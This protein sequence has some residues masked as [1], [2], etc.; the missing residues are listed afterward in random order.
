[1]ADKQVAFVTIG[2][3][4]RT[5]MMPEMLDEIGPGIA[6]HEFGILDGLSADEVARLRPRGAGYRL[7]S[8]MA[9]GSEVEI[10]K[11]WAIEA[12]QRKLDAVDR[13]GFDLVVLLCTGSFPN[14][15]TRT[16]MVE[17]GRVIDNMVDAIGEEH[18]TV[19]VL[20]PNESQVASWQRSE[21]GKARAVAAHASPYTDRR[22]AAAV[23]ELDEA[24]FIVMHCMGYDRAMRDE[25]AALSGKPVLL[26][27]AMVA[28]AVT[29]LI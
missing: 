3:A 9:D 17:A 27:R 6:G 13:E 22:F 11:P 8:R 4:P 2:Q 21:P 28:S 18:R 29:Q 14:F 23:L 19:G 15:H 26:S 20:L 12:V 24:E 25:V 1:M 5:D 16:L 7:V 10:D